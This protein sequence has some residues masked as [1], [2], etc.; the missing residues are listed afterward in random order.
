MVVFG[1]RGR[2][3]RIYLT[4]SGLIK[5][6]IFSRVNTGSFECHF[7]SSFFFLFKYIYSFNPYG[8]F[9]Y[10]YNFLDKSLPMS[11]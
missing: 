2:E 1:V 5:H 11:V 6:V 8:N 9:C 3:K 4:F 7:T 10:V